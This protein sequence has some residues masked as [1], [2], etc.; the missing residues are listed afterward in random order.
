MQRR[1]LSGVLERFLLRLSGLGEASARRGNLD[2]RRDDFEQV[3]WNFDKC[4]IEGVRAN[5]ARARHDA[6]EDDL[7]FDNGK[8][9]GQLQVVHGVHRDRARLDIYERH[10]EE[11]VLEAL[12][13]VADP[14]A[15]D[16]AAGVAEV[17]VLVNG[18]HEAHGSVALRLM[19][20]TD[21]FLLHVLH[22]QVVQI[23]EED[24]LLGVLQ[25]IH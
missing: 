15:D 2:G 21:A 8:A 1:V 23:S 25:V 22:V 7:L 9:L 24:Q 11:P 4:K 18:I 6:V 12:R 3:A 17:E 19:S 14:A 10:A 16:I 20:T 5:F 13:G